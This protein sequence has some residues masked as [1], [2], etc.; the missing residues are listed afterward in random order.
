MEGERLGETSL[1]GCASR[2]GGCCVY[3]II[4]LCLQMWNLCCL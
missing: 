3:E 2:G 4:E 1:L